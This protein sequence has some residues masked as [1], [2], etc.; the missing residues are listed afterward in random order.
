MEVVHTQPSFWKDNNY[1]Y[2]KA[3]EISESELISITAELS[4]YDIIE[5]LMWNDRNG[6]YSDED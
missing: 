2:L 4:R 3:V 6:V 1:P 5:W